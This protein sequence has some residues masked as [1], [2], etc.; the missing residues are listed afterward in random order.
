M[1]YIS[2]PATMISWDIYDLSSNDLT[3]KSE[4]IHGISEKIIAWSGEA[5]TTNNNGCLGYINREL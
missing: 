4:E 2:I 3:S 5:V 1:G